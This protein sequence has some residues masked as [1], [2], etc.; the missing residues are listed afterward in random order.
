MKQD[1]IYGANC[2][3]WFQ[4]RKNSEKREK[5]TANTILKVDIEMTAFL[6]Y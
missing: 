3:P 5:R 1:S 6:K 2:F 4:K